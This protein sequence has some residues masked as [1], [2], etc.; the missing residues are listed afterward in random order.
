MATE[1]QKRAKK[2]YRARLKE[3]GG[4]YRVGL[5]FYPPDSDLVEYLKTKKPIN[6]YIKK[7]IRED[8]ER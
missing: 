2:N 5:D 8:M 1:A 6:T 7:L 3:K 4:L